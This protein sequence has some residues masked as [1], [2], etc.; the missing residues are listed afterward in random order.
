MLDFLESKCFGILSNIAFLALLANWSVEKVSP[1]AVTEGEIQTINFILPGP[2]KE[3]L[4]I[5]VNLESL[6][7]IWVLDFSIKAEIQWPKHDKLLLIY[8]SYWTLAYLSETVKS[9]GILYFSDPAKSTIFRD[10]DLT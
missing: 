6:K 8:L 3:S 1:L 7:G 5:R 10:E 2:T 4:K 9:I